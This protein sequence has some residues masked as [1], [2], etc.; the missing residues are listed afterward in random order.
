M[1]HLPSL[2]PMDSLP[3]EDGDVTRF[4]VVLEA[5]SWLGTPYEHQHRVKG[6]AVDCVGL[7]IGVARNLGV[8]PPEF[9]VNAYPR[10]PDG[11]TLLARCA[12]F[13][14]PV[15]DEDA[16]PGHVLVLAFRRDP[17]HMGILGD[18]LYGGL[19]LIHAFGQ[20]DGGCVEER[21]L[22]HDLKAFRPLRV[23][24]LRGVR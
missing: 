8:V 13:M 17:Q 11:S 5:R 12:E 6:H 3:G 10:K 14:D 18:Y 1:M 9:D 7:V 19:S 2:A 4:D 21:N 15:R 22:H 16:R 23:F 24:A 20:G